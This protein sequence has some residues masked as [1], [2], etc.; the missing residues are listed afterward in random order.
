MRFSRAR[1]VTLCQQSLVTA[2]VLAV[3]VSAAGVKTLDIVPQPGTGRRSR[4]RRPR[5][6]AAR[7]SRQDNAS[8]RQKTEV[9]AAPVTP[10]VRE[11][12]VTGISAKA[13]RAAGPSAACP[14]RHPARSSRRRADV[15]ADRR[16]P[17]GWSLFPSPQPVHGYATVG[18]TWKHGV[19][20]RRGPDRRARCAPRRTARWSGWTTAEYHDEHGPDAGSTEEDARRERPG[21]DALVIGDVDRV[22][23]RAETADGSTPP[24]LKLAVIDPGTGAMT[25]Q[26]PGD[27]HREADRR[28]RGSDGS[29]TSP[30]AL[31]CDHSDGRT[32]RR[33]D[34]VALSAMKPRREPKIF[35]RAQWGANERM[36]EQAP[37]ELR[38]RQDRL[39]PPHGQREQLHRGARCPSLLRGIYAYHTQS[40]GWRDIGYNYLVDRFGRIWEGRYGGVNRAVVGAHTL[41]YNEVLLRD[42][43]DRQLRHRPAAGRGRRPPTR[44]CSPG[45]SRSTTSART[46]RGS[47]EGPL[48]PRDQRPP[49]RRPD[50]LS[51]PLPLRAASPTSAPGPGASRSPPRRVASA[52]RRAAHP[53]RAHGPDVHARRPRPRVRPQRSRRSPSRRHEPGRLVYPDLVAEVARQRRHPRRR[54]PAARPASAR[55]GDHAGFLV[56]DEPARR[57]R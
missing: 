48:P 8:R 23:M 20:V 38:H 27:R 7:G 19:A 36:R 28:R 46:T 57:R 37:P 45:S 11:V 3:G 35:S 12:K 6:A 49:R 43:G 42:V 32:G 31:R 52:P 50:R 34:T 1:Y 2:A 33:Q 21:T 29:A 55:H 41:G 4:G 47:C 17:S 25:K 13:P 18:V 16:A 15:H 10:K 54:P 44:S 26:A 14:R 22:Q 30:Q 40:R 39:H 56:G 24:D 51:G 53:E 5:C 9:D